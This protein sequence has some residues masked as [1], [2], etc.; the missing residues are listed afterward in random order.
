MCVCVC[1]CV[2]VC[3]RV[4]VCSFQVHRTFGVL[5]TNKKETRGCEVWGFR[6][7]PGYEGNFEKLVE[8]VTIDHLGTDYDY[9]SVMHYPGDAFAV[10]DNIP[11]IVTRDPAAQDVIGQRVRMSEADIERIQVLYECV[12]AVSSSSS[13]VVCSGADRQIIREKERRM[14]K[15]NKRQVQIFDATRERDNCVF[16]IGSPGSHCSWSHPCL[17]RSQT[18]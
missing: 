9:G 2:C 12:S 1:V 5:S 6:L 10:N 13:A 3:A 17:C 15:L 16:E 4:R 14:W 11:T 8:N 7:F 18:E